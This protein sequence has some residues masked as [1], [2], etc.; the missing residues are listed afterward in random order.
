MLARSMQNPKQTVCKRVLGMEGDE[1]RVRQS[2]KMGP[3]RTVL[4]SRTPSEQRR[5]RPHDA[6]NLLCCVSI[7][8]TLTS[9]ASS[10][11]APSEDIQ[12][13]M[14]DFMA[15]VTLP[16]WRCGCSAHLITID[17]LQKQW[18]IVMYLSSDV[19]GV[20]VPAGHVWLQGDNP[21]NSTDS[22]HYG[23]VPYALLRGRAFLKVS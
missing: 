4:V 16:C 14:T 7:S 12:H 6:R 19:H 22:R 15:E 5:L 20:Q 17:S 3:G 10:R 23:P 9:S 21:I 13:F 18:Q 2:S 1:V 11:E 8:R